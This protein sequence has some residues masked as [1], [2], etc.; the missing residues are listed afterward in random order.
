MDQLLRDLKFGVRT[1]LYRAQTHPS[2][3]SSSTTR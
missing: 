3:R 1:L 2:T